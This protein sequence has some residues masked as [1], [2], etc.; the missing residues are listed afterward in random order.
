MAFVAVADT[1]HFGR[2]AERLGIAQPAISQLIRRLEDHLGVVLFERTSHRVSITPAGQ[3]L[4]PD[5]RSAIA[6][7]QRLGDRASQLAEGSAATLRVAT[8]T[9]IGSRLAELLTRYH[10]GHPAV[11]LDLQVL[12][13]TQKLSGVATGTIDVAFLRSTPPPT[14][15]LATRVAWSEPYVAVVPAEFAP[16]DGQR[17]DVQALGGLPLLVVA[18]AEHPTMHDE[19]L[20]VCRS[21]GLEPQ[22]R[23]RPAAAQ[24]T[25]ALVA[26][27]AAW[28]LF[29]D[30]NVPRLAGVH[31]CE[32]PDGTPPS[33]VWLVWRQIGAPT[34]VS[35]FVEVAAA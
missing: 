18:R 12:T 34:H 13:T 22:T 6:T 23:P 30:G 5:A 19:L 27:G 24:D 20:D 14:P 17:L 15:E 7:V 33:R 9:G 10:Q 28:T 8:T 29:I 32:L 31:A 25:L 21:L 16:E 11:A 35:D 3:T 2:A 4:L 26:A 1:L